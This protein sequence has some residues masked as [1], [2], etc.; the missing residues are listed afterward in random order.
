MMRSG[1]FLSVFVAFASTSVAAGA[2]A[3][4]AK[5]LGSTLDYMESMNVDERLVVAVG[6]AAEICTGLSKS[7]RNTMT[8]VAHMS[9]DDRP[10]MLGTAANPEEDRAAYESACP[11]WSRQVFA[12]RFVT[13]PPKSSEVFKACR[14]ER[15]HLFSLKEFSAVDARVA[16]FAVV[17]H[18]LLV[19][20]ALDASLAR[21]LARMIVL[22]GEL[23]VKPRPKRIPPSKG[24]GS[25]DAGVE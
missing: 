2:P 22:P 4:D 12:E 21:R 18:Q 15:L 11:G 14:F 6:I 24:R 8:A 9:P 25:P 10:S 13:D 23:P 7:L 17:L 1:Y 20:R 16:T 19:E 5:E 3:C